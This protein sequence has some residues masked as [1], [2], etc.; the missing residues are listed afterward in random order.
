MH[1]L[2]SLG[3][4][5]FFMA[6]SFAYLAA[7]YGLLRGLRFLV[8][9]MKGR[10][11]PLWGGTPRKKAVF[12]LAVVVAFYLSLY[13]S[14]YVKWCGSDNAHLKAKQYFAVGQTLAGLR[15]TVTKVLNPDN[16][17][18]LPLNTLQ[19]LIYLQGSRY[20]PENDGEIGVWN[21]LWFN[22]P[23]IQRMAV[24]Y[25]TSDTEPS[26]R[27][28]NLLDSIWFSMEQM[29]T[30]SFVDKQMEREQY[31]Q[32]FP[33]MAFYYFI[34]K[35]YYNDRLIGSNR[36]LLQDPMYLY[37]LKKFYPWLDELRNRWIKNNIYKKIKQSKPKIETLR[38]SVS[39]GVLGKL[40]ES[41]IY[42]KNFSCENV[43][44][45]LYIE[46]RREFSD[47][48]S[49]NYVFGRYHRQEK[50]QAELIYQGT[51]DSITSSFKKY[52]IEHYCKIEVPG[53]EAFFE[54]LDKEYYRNTREATVRY[55]FRNE[56]KIIEEG[57]HAVR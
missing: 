40:I 38:Q 51:I 18:L 48:N 52:I 32:N 7:G 1:F 49:I 53:E 33:R 41:S 13:A 8:L 39:I 35:G 31:F 26:Y 57:H 44:I 34:N 11:E 6:V 54:K 16:P 27:M 21:D 12:G 14:M 37:R 55:V 56:I 29:S 43:Y 15:L 23:Y 36:D 42:P 22:Y 25:G 20:L 30:K 5:V 45:H 10:N 46:A 3:F 24:P 2:I 28:R 9:R 50:E 47:P 17:V 19:R 4:L